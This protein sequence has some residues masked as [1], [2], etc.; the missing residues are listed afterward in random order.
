MACFFE[1][2]GTP[3]TVP[4]APRMTTL[5]SEYRKTFH[6]QTR[7]MAHVRT[8]VCRMASSG[9]TCVRHELERLALLHPDRRHRN[10][11]RWTTGPRNRLFR[12]GVPFSWRLCVYAVFHGQDGAQARRW[13]IKEAGCWRAEIR[14]QLQDFRRTH[15]ALLGHTHHVDHDFEH[16]SRFTDIVDAFLNTGERRPLVYD[17]I[18]G[19]S[20][21]QF[22]D[23]DFA[24]RWQ[25]YHLIHAKLRMLDARS[26]LAGNR[27]F[28][29]KISL[30]D[31]S[32]RRRIVEP[33]SYT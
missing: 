20:G 17:V 29:K 4:P 3:C 16:G 19:V 22:R 33:T 23:R 9:E 11:L 26:N 13:Q 18:S 25:E 31:P 2:I 12:D 21:V 5:A 6:T 7:M 8:L 1:G 14:S 24:K 28:R 27:G 15:G 30:S 32:K 10:G